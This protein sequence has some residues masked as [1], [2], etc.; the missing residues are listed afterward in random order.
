M[1]RKVK[2]GI[3]GLIFSNIS[4]AQSISDLQ[5]KYQKI[6]CKILEKSYETCF[7]A[8]QRLNI[9]KDK[10]G[11][12]ELSIEIFK[13]T[14]EEYKATDEAFL[15]LAKRASLVCFKACMGEDEIYNNIKEECGN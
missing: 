12:N 6:A 5:L 7:E 4:F 11:C 10:S 2:I 9:F 14:V 8:S 13:A 15:E 1:L 3:L